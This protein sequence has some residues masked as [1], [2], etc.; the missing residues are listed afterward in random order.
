MTLL[1]DLPDFP[2]LFGIAERTQPDPAAFVEKDY[3]VTQVLRSL[4]RI[5]PGGFALKG[6]TSL[7]KGYGIINR[8][9]EDV[10]ILVI[11]KQGESIAAGERR[12]KDLTEAVAHDLG[13]GWRQSREPTR[14]RHAG[15][16][17]HI[18]YPGSTP[19]GPDMPVAA[20]TVL[21]E[22]RIAS[23]DAPVKM[24]TMQ[25]LIARMTGIETG[26]YADLEPFDIRVLEPRRTL[27]EKISAVHHE[28]LTFTPEMADQKTRIG[29]H[30]YDIYKLLGHKDTLKGLQAHEMSMHLIAE[31]QMISADVYRGYSPRPEAGYGASPAFNPPHGSDVRAWLEKSYATQLGLLSPAETRPAFTDVLL[32]VADHA[33]LL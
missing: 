10:D 25:C 5:A 18:V 28:V 32:R 6:G 8:L 24:C 13:L 33:D 22:T 31:I 2:V 16:A 15:R 12:L 20:N 14:G 23:S 7:S 29:R 19:V 27:L 30:Y 9:S 4:H 21:L 1:R 26:T 11:G 3:W 17:D